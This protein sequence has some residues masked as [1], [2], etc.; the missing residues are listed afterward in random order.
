MSFKFSNFDNHYGLLDSTNF[1]LYEFGN[2]LSICD[3][4]L[5]GKSFIKSDDYNQKIKNF[6]F[7]PKHNF[8]WQKFSIFFM[9]SKGE[10]F[11]VCPIFLINFQ[12]HNSYLDKNLDF[13]NNSNLT[14][15]DKKRLKLANISNTNLLKNIKESIEKKD[16][17]L[18]IKSN[19]YL[20][21]MNKNPQLSQIIVLDKRD[22]KP[23]KEFL[24]IFEY[25]DIIV[26]DSFPILIL[27]KSDLG[28]IDIILL[29]DL[30]FPIR[31]DDARVKW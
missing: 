6:S 25:N 7:G 18:H 4:N 19:K 28:L 3:I 29:N 12:L 10:I 14:E 23:F 1:R 2:S 13:H 5:I 20:L 21:E 27:R 26:L 30:L 15:E 22:S 17:F 16:N 9:S 24:K 31:T 8:G 11:V